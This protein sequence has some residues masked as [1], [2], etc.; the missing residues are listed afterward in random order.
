MRTAMDDT[1]EFVKS[2]AKSM[3]YCS[4]PCIILEILMEMAIPTSF[5]G[6]EFLKMAIYLRYLNPFWTVTNNIYPAIS[7][8]YG[9]TLTND[10]IDK[11]IWGAINEAWKNVDIAVWRLFLP[12]ILKN[13]NKKPSNTEFIYE[14]ARIAELWSG[15]AEAYERQCTREGV[16][17]EL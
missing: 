2:R 3:R 1:I 8:Q 4:V 15:C 12:T 13:K 16:S 9:G 5:D 14:L 10:Q 17:H 7:A 6:F 11:A